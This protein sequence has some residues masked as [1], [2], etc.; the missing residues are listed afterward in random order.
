MLTDELNLKTIIKISDKEFDLELWSVEQGQ[1]TKIKLDGKSYSLDKDTIKPSLETIEEP[2]VE[3]ETT[4]EELSKKKMIRAPNNTLLFLNW[5]KEG[6]IEEFDI[7]DF[8]GKYPYVTTEQAKLI[9]AQQI[10]KNNLRQRSNT[11]FEVLRVND[12]DG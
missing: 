8:T 9:I 1:I 11:H 4:I 7:S 3:K 2:V 10:V 5:L 6:K 12:E